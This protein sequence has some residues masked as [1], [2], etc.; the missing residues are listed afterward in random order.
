MPDYTQILYEKQRQGA[1][2]TLNRPETNN[3]MNRRM[4]DEMYER[5]GRG[6]G[7]PGGPGHC[8]DGRRQ[9]LLL[10]LRPGGRR[11]P[12]TARD[13]LALRHYR[14]H[15]RGGVHRRPAQR[16][17]QQLPAA[18]VGAGQAGHRRNQRLGN[19]RRLLVRPLQPHHHRLRE[20]R[21]LPAG[22]ATRIEHQLHLD[23]D[24]RVQHAIATASPATTSMRRRLCASALSTR[25]SPTSSCW[26]SALASWSGLP[27]CRL[28]R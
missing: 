12:A 20:R 25:W 24:D 5:H 17:Q 10:R 11:L 19:G 7:R 16:Q 4:Q 6:R 3:A 15:E 2:I 14:G 21:F 23:A 22:G 13:G 9:R 1:L 27:W 8:P 26:T 28:R 18:P